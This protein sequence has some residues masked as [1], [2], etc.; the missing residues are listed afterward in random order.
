MTDER[1]ASGEVLLTKTCGLAVNSGSKRSS[2][3]LTA[4]SMTS[5]LKSLR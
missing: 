5:R 3:R 1:P 4:P 2:A